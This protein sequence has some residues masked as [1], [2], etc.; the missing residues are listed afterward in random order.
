MSLVVS[1]CA[2]K[3]LLVKIVQFVLPNRF[4]VC[5]YS[6]HNSI[7]L[8]PQNGMSFSYTPLWRT[9]NARDTE[10]WM[11]RVIVL[12]CEFGNHRPRQMAGIANATS[13]LE[14]GALNRF[15]FRFHQFK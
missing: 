9:A 15:K 10:P 6:R 13:V 14:K 7:E 3:K 1:L 12:N 5:P 11:N 4:F 8:N 2:G